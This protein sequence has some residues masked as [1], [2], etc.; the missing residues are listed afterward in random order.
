MRPGVSRAVPMGLLGFLLA[1]LV[2]VVVRTLQQL[3]PP[4]DP[5]LAVVFGA[6][7]MAAG[8]IWGL[9]AFDPRM[10]VHAHEP[11]EDEDE[12][13][14]E[15]V[16]HAEEPESK[17]SEILGGYIWLLSTLLIALLL[18]LVAFAELPEGPALKT[19]H[20]P[21]ADVAAVGYE[22][23]ILFGQTFEV[24]QL[25][26][27]IGFAIVMFLSLT[28]IAGLVGM[29]FFNLSRGLTSVKDVEQTALAAEPLEHADTSQRGIVRWGIV[30]AVATVAFALFDRL[31]NQPITNEFQTLSFFLAGGGIF[32][33]AFVLL[34]YF[35]RAVASRTH[36]LWLVRA[37]II[38]GG[39]NLVLIGAFLIVWLAVAPLPMINVAV[40]NLVILGGLLLGRMVV[41]S[42]YAILVGILI[43]LF[44]FVLIGLVV[45]FAPPLLFFISLN[46]ALLVA[47][48][49]LRPKFVTHWLGYGASWTAKQLRRVP[50]MMQ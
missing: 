29:L 5:Q 36:W 10:N 6:F 27:L 8:F 34:G 18:I 43:P 50:N 46:N 25:L 21:L 23:L 19:V 42:M 20:D 12:T 30:A 38:V 44:Y 2:L 39:V 22:Q 32:A 13:A 24:S 35:I 15:V 49:V 31:M 40:L 45:S 1:M 3:D 14:I 4:L 17:P 41:A 9:G 26:L 11:P 7:T 48:I 16:E 47:A 37:I 33:I 28:A